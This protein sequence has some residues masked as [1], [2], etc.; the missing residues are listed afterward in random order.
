[1]D[2]N[3]E[4]FFKFLDSPDWNHEKT[5]NLFL[6]LSKEKDDLIKK[7]DK[8]LEKNDKNFDELKKITDLT[9]EKYDG[10]LKLCDK[11]KKENE[12]L[13]AKKKDVSCQTYV[14]GVQKAEI[15][16]EASL[17]P[18]FLPT[19]HEPSKLELVPSISKLNLD[20]LWDEAKEIMANQEPFK[21]KNRDLLVLFVD[22]K[23]SLV[24]LMGRDWYKKCRTCVQQYTM[25][26]D[27]AHKGLY[28]KMVKLLGEVFE[29]DW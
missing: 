2:F 15:I 3:K 25:T 22:Y 14:C 5:Y 4:I 13:R 1:M 9:F 24:K 28:Q 19:I 26:D 27:I 21:D 16:Y 17:T 18:D 11:L 8:Q 7:L 10:C 6:R 20:T 12:R 23:N 29:K